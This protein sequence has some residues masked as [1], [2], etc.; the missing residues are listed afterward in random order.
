MKSR[1]NCYPN[2]HQQRIII[3]FI[4]TGL[5]LSIITIIS[6]QA[7]TESRTAIYG[8]LAMAIG[9]GASGMRPGIGVGLESVSKIGNYVGL[10]G[11]IDYEWLTVDIPA[12]EDIRLG[13]HLWDVSFVPKCYIPFTESANMSFEVDPGFCLSLAY[14]HGDYSD[15]DTKPHFS[16]TSGIAFNIEKFVLAFKFKR[17]FSIDGTANIVTFNVGYALN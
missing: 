15:S 17:I 10:G 8:G 14:V 16:L 7:Q 3:R 12:D 2:H 13:V 4:K 11:H 6:I 1:T 5:L 9:D